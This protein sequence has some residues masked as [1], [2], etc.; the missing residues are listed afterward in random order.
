MFQV[1]FDEQTIVSQREPIRA[2]LTEMLDLVTRLIRQFNLCCS[3]GQIPM[4]TDER[5]A[6]IRVKTE[7]AKKH[8]RDLEIAKDN[9]INSNPHSVG[10]KPMRSRV[11]KG[12]MF[13]L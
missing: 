4:N 12:L 2:T 1:S 13:G 5:L 11:M 10:F 9:S 3:A 7:R 8:L 6:L